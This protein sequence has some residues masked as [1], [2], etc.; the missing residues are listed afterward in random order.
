MVDVSAWLDD[1][2]RNVVAV[3]CK[4]GKGRTGLM[5]CCL[6]LWRGYF[7]SMAD[8]LDFYAKM[9]TDD[10]DG[11]TIPSQ[12]RFCLYFE[13]WLTRPG[14]ARSFS[15]E[16][17]PMLRI[18]YIA[19]E[20]APKAL[21]ARDCFFSILQSGGRCWRGEE[22]TDS[23]SL[24]SK[25]KSSTVGLATPGRKP[26]L[27]WDW[28]PIGNGPLDLAR[29]AVV[30]GDVRIDL[31]SKDKRV[32]RFWFHTAFVEKGL[33][34]LTKIELDGPHKDRKCKHYEEEFAVSVYFDTNP[35]CEDA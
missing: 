6:L 12:R 3:H 24:G 28:G 29:G 33:L 14:C 26:S 22:L 32:L 10:M 11:V 7:K 5:V 34:R 13:H 9:R 15:P 20:P 23:R 16:G 8:A 4:A 35:A 30:R 25:I 19:L 31:H 21:S 27:E 2:P 18:K 17:P 1:H